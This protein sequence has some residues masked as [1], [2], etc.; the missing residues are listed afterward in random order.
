MVDFLFKRVLFYLRVRE[1]FLFIAVAVD[2]LQDIADVVRVGVYAVIGYESRRLPYIQLIALPDPGKLL[3]LLLRVNGVIFVKAKN[4]I[5]LQVDIHAVRDCGRD[6]Y[7]PAEISL[8][9]IF[10][11]FDLLGGIGSNYLHIV[12][13][14]VFGVEE[15][16]Y[17]FCV[18]FAIA[19]DK[20]A[21]FL[22]L[23]EQLIEALFADE[24]NLFFSVL[25]FVVYEQVL[26]IEVAAVLD[27]LQ[28]EVAKTIIQ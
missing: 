13:G 2:E 26:F 17:V 18:F 23:L 4:T 24:K 6:N 11:R 21:L 28:T 25:V 10:E 27:K 12:F 7:D 15:R 5:V 19:A 14:H 16:I 3:K 1:H 20:K 9:D 8:G 22:F